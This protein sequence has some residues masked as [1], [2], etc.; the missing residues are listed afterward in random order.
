MQNK[1]EVLELCAVFSFEL[2]PQ[3]TV[4]T[5]FFLRS[6]VQI[7]FI[8]VQIITGTIWITGIC[9]T[10]QILVPVS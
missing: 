7:S 4:N 3:T 2:F 10:V 9:K 6:D 1:P 8:E 5:F